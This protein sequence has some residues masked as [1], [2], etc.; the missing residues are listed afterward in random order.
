MNTS[1]V[2]LMAL[3]ILLCLLLSGCAWFAD[4]RQPVSHSSIDPNSPECRAM[5][6]W[7]LQTR[8]GNRWGIKEYQADVEYFR[9]LKGE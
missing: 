5:L 1:H 3:I 7:I 4:N 2:L 6:R 8:A 9:Y